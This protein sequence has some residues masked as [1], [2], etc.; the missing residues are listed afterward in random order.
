MKKFGTEII[1]IHGLGQKLPEEIL[2]PIW[3]KFLLCGSE[4]NIPDEAVQMAYWADCIPNH[5]PE[6]IRTST[7]KAVQDLLEYVAVNKDNFHVGAGDKVDEFFAH[8]GKELINILNSAIVL[9]ENIINSVSED[10]KYYVL[11]SHIAEQMR[12]CLLSKIVSAWQRKKKVVIVAHSMGSVIAYDLFWELSY[13][14]EYA[15]YSGNK[16]EAFFTMGSPLDNKEVQVNLLSSSYRKRGDLFYPKN[17][18]NWYNF[19]C[20]GDVV[21]HNSQIEEI[22]L[23][24]MKNLGILQ[25]FRDYKN[26]YNPYVCSGYHNPH[27]S[28]GYLVQPKLTKCLNKILLRN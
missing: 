17:L 25:D 11:D 24:P 15:K 4:M 22:L 7:D 20:L 16:I 3:R 8:K 18:L 27:K 1:F 6:N 5:I 23:K 2:L 21:T 12:G 28:Y 10:A 26:L 14:A 19:S 9:K 13:R